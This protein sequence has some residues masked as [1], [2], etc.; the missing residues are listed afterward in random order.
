MPALFVAARLVL[1]AVFA[2]AGAAKLADRSGTRRGVA[3]FGIPDRFAGPVAIALPFAE[4]AIAAA[5][6][7]E[8]T[9]WFAAM[10]AVGLLTVFLSAIGLNLA[11]GRKPDCH[12]FG[13]IHSAPVGPTTLALNAALLT[14]AGA[15]VWRGFV[16]DPLPSLVAWIGQLQ[17]FELATLSGGAVAIALLSAIAFL[18][19]QM[20]RQQGRVLL[21][22]D[23]LEA[24]LIGE[25][26]MAGPAPPAVYDPLTMGAGLPVGNRAPAF[27]LDAVAGKPVTLDQLLKPRKPI[28]FLFANPHCGPCEA[29]LPEVAEWQR[30]Y[31]DVFSTVVISE[32]SRKE[33]RTKVAKHGLETILLQ[34]KQEIAELYQAWGT[35]AALFVNSDGVIATRVAQ[36]AD[37]IRS[38][39]DWGARRARGNGNGSAAQ[40]K[41][42]T[43]GE[44]VPPLQ[45]PNVFGK[46]VDVTSV[47]ARRTML[48]FWNPGCGFCQQMLG[49]LKAWEASRPP[50]APELLVISAG[51]V[52]VNRGMNLRSP[53]LLDQASKAATI[54]GAG[55]TPMAVMLDGN[56]TVSSEVA[57]GAELVFALA[58]SHP[59]N[60]AEAMTTTQ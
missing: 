51:T 3:G 48:L 57:G 9:A 26:A 54:F 34:R 35:P 46:L 25:G 6:L 43:I 20:L 22:L 21:R 30:G 28:L 40:T 13:Q 2:V 17:A 24:R 39:V 49:D 1:F 7:P 23:D 19:W 56:G 5:L 36:G 18:M 12:C 31:A 37:A 14:M 16:G 53:V 4:L 11:L 41:A 8:T 42:I 32:G 50:E 45:L 59:V 38:L 15:I 47:N 10:L 29:L 52:E 33:N 60:A 27:E 44:R 55:G 58:N